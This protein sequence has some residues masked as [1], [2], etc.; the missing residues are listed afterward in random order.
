MA[1]YLLMQRSY[2]NYDE[3]DG[4]VIRA[5]D[6]T[7]ARMLANEEVGDEG[8]IWNDENEVKCEHISGDGITCV[9]LDS[10]RAG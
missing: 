2:V 3:Y 8:K 5:K 10:F 1:I 4:K 6:E 9:I 7:E